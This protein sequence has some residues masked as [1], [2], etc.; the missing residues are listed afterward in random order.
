[1]IEDPDV[2]ESTG[3]NEALGDFTI[4]G[5][6]RRVATWMVVDKYDSVRRFRECPFDDFSGID[7][8]FGES[9]LKKRLL[10]EDGITAAEKNDLEDLSLPVAE[11]GTER[12]VD[13]LARL[14]DPLHPTVAR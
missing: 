6:G 13:I 11:V 2:H 7:L 14:D 4:L 1:V 3:L 8:A 5:T 12:S 9:S 10:F